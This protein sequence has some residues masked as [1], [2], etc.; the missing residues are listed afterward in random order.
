MA[1]LAGINIGQNGFDKIAYGLE[2]VQSRSFLVR[3][4]RSKGFEV[5]L[6]A[7]DRWDPESRDLKIDTSIYDADT[8]TWV[9]REGVPKDYI[10]VEA[11]KDGLSVTR[12]SESGFVT[13]AFEHYSPEFAKAMVVSLVTALN[14]EIRR[15]DV[16][17][18][19]RSLDFLKGQMEATPIAAL[20]SAFASL[21]EEQ[22]QVVMLANVSDEYLLTTIDPPVEA[23][24][25]VKP[26]RLLLVVFVFFLS[27]SVAL[28]ACIV[29]SWVSRDPA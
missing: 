23:S 8:K 2:V 13:I 25:P 29:W 20:R 27:L 7:G 19:S 26:K 16:Q 18:A 10:L 11:I 22:A 5:P 4:A 15:Q 6:L 14:E 17:R 21:I 28:T 3:L 9:W 24:L 1:R 12:D